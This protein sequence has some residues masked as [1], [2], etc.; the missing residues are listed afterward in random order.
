MH[1]A[2]WMTTVPHRR[3]ARGV[4]RPWIP[5][6]KCFSSIRARQGCDYRSSWSLN[7]SETKGDALEGAD[8]T[9]GLLP[10]CAG[11]PLPI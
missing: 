2:S 9:F 5:V 10:G 4:V 6:V 7:P 11:M 8:E 1:P 3:D